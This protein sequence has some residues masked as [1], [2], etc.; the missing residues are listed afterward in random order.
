MPLLRHQPALLRIRPPCP[1]LPLG[2]ARRCP[3]P[4]TPAVKKKKGATA[5]SETQQPAAA[6]PPL[7]RKDGDGSRASAVGSSSQD[8][9]ARP[10]EKAISIAK[11]APEAPAPSL[12]A[13]V[14]KAQEPPTPSAAANLQ[15][16]LRDNLQGADRRL[17][18]GRLEL[19]SGW[20]R[21]DASVRA[22]WSQ[23][24][25]ASE[26]GKQAADLAMDAREVALKDA[27]AAKERYR[28]AE[29]ELETL[30]N[31]RAAEARRREAWDGKLKAREDVVADR[32]TELEQS[33]R[34]QAAERGRLEKLKEE[35]EAEKAQPK[36]K[37]KVLSKDRAAFNSL[38]LRSRK[39]LRELYGR[40]L[41]KL[42]VTAK[43]GPAELLPQLVT[44]LE[45]VVNGVGPMVEGEARALSASAMT[46]VF[47][48]LHLR[49][50][51]IDLGA[52]LEP[53]DEEHCTAATEAVKDRVQTLL[54]KFLAVEP[55][56]PAD[57]VVD[58]TAAA[59]GMGD[60]D[61]VDEGALLMGDDSAQG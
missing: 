46:R 25:T 51:S 26:E 53:V 37:A 49:D 11:P 20:L 48:H 36:A 59:D 55:M 43:E 29:A 30:R 7:A 13:K 21:S 22:A 14:A 12:P 40:G 35:V 16:L 6:V 60:S 24:V 39:A 54:E 8:P 18:S 42:L 52:L 23:A 28:G 4:P 2:L 50:P 19:V 58:P 32:D 47:S 1:Y 56:P 27:E 5:I 45:G 57:G 38:E 17:A 9:E 15:A 41:K 33:A 34:A 44:A 3:S 61:V 10:Q 31:K